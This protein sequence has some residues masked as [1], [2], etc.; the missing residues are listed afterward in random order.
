M[1]DQ[2]EAIEGGCSCRSVRYRLVLS[3]LFVH[4]CHCTWC[5]RET[6]SA[7]VLNAMVEARGVELL[8]GEPRCVDT[9]SYSGRGQRVYRCPE[10]L[11]ALWSCYSTAGEKLRFLRVGT[12]DEPSRCPPDV[13]IF[14][15]T[16]QPWVKLE[17]GVPVMEAFYDREALFPPETL[18]RWHRLMSQ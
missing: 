8:R 15:G 12:L 18:E 5:Q 6:G 2:W 3:P 17:D 9:P 14:T 1:S 7:F 11:V 13:H 4:C 10:C 16:R